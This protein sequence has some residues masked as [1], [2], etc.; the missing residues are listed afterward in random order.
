MSFV[1]TH[2]RA[3]VLITPIIRSS[4]SLLMARL[5][6]RAL[7]IETPDVSATKS[8]TGFT[9]ISDGVISTCHLLETLTMSPREKEA[10]KVAWSQSGKP[11][12]LSLG[13][14]GLRAGGQTTGLPACP[15]TGFLRC[16]C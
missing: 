5:T 10:W 9:Q 8:T 14:L 3:A 13:R 11:S 12:F 2:D 16:F 4:S 15:A 1:I 6:V 7:H